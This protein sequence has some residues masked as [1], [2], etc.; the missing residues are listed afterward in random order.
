MKK[1]NNKNIA[2]IQTVKTLAIGLV[3]LYAWS[4]STIGITSEISGEDLVQC[5]I[6]KDKGPNA[7][8][9]IE[10]K[11]DPR[12]GLYISQAPNK[13]FF[14][15]Q[16][17]VNSVPGAQTL[18][19]KNGDK[20]NAI[21]L[22]QVVMKKNLEDKLE[23]EADRVLDY[24]EGKTDGISSPIV[25]I[26]DINA[27]AANT[28]TDR[29]EAVKALKAKL[30][31][32]MARIEKGNQPDLK[33]LQSLPGKCD[34]LGEELKEEITAYRDFTEK[35]MAENGTPFKKSIGRHTAS[36]NTPKSAKTLK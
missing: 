22:D 29:E 34:S 15:P 30:K 35:W 27:Y 21:D 14:I 28:D 32:E 4:Q 3:A 5:T 1:Q 26:P 19:F 2:D 10:S 6:G 31:N 33:V 23:E 12:K 7:Y 36:I 18:E 8:N 24:V 25:S 9:V 20:K 13:L 11:V 17:K 16:S